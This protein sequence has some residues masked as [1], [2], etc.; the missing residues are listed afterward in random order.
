MNMHKSTRLFLLYFLVICVIVLFSAWKFFAPK[1]NYKPPM[2]KIASAVKPT[3]PLTA[4]NLQTTNEQAF[5]E[6]SLRG[7]WT[8]MFFGYTR[9]PD[10]CPKTLALVRDSWNIFKAAKQPVPVRFVFAD[11]SREPVTSS[12]LK[13]FLQNYA[14]EFIGINGD[15]AQLHQLSDQLGIYAQQESDKIDHTAALMLLDPQGRLHAVFT[16]PFSAEEL[17]HDLQVLTR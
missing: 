12:E 2:T 15:L 11:I 9:C 14:A 5:T 16:P 6:K 1:F 17:V 4:F 7:H 8:L 13:M 10:I 3:G